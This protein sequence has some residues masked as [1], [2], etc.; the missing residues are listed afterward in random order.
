MQPMRNGFMTRSSLSLTETLPSHPYNNKYGKW[1]KPI[2]LMS[3]SRTTAMLIVLMWRCQPDREGWPIPACAL[4]SLPLINSFLAPYSW[5]WSRQSWLGS[6]PPT[7]G[8]SLC[9]FGQINLCGT[10]SPEAQP[11]HSSQPV[12]LPAHDDIL[13]PAAYLEKP[14]TPRSVH[15]HGKTGHAGLRSKQWRILLPRTTK[16]EFFS[17]LGLYGWFHRQPGAFVLVCMFMS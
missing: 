12:A 3:S 11:A 15:W 7:T 4:P 8:T 14:Q 10:V 6:G 13:S 16:L 5:F 2:F 9:H 1:I 17:P